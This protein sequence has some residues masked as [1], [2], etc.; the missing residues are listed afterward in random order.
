M[1]LI[2]VIT[3]LLISRRAVVDLLLIVRNADL[4]LPALSAHL[5]IMSTL[6]LLVVHALFMEITVAHVMLLIVFN[7]KL[8]I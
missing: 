7:A 8:D 5:L 4:R 1:D 3:V 6:T 2:N